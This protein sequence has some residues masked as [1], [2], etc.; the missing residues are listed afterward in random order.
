MLRMIHRTL[1]RLRSSRQRLAGCE[2]KIRDYERFVPPGHFYSPIPSLDEVTADSAR[3]FDLS[4]DHLPGI[5]LREAEQLAL[6][7]E[8]AGFYAEMP[9]SEQPDGRRRFH[10]D[11]PFYSYGDAIVLYAMLRRFQPR[12]Y[13]EIG[14]G[15][16]SAVALDTN[17]LFLGGRM[18]CTFIEPYPNH[19]RVLLRAGDAGRVRILQR[20]LQDV[21]LSVFA[22][23]EPGD[24]LF[25]DSTHVA[26]CGSDV[27]RIFF[28]IL[29]SL[30]RGVLI[31]LHDIFFPF[32]Y[33]QAWV[34][35]GR[36]WNELYMLRTFL[37]F[38]DTFQIRLFNHYLGLCHAARWQGLMPLC[39]RNF[40]G[41]MWLEKC[42]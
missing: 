35:E 40:G 26:K 16:S 7:D 5:E 37:Q 23:L 14:S 13:V 10:F 42:R 34:L 6:L 41:A 8:L 27:N 33:P 24:V 18:Q 31:H 17:E 9:F 25:I 30:P 36:A 28:H 21:D 32:E 15:F 22:E 3:I 38:N 39:A 12:R 1:D 11:N 19:L 4:G 2:A 20:R 29:P